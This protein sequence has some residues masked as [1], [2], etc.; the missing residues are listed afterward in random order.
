[1]A[2]KAPPLILKVKPVLPVADAVMLPFVATADVGLTVVAVKEIVIPAQ[3]LGAVKVNA[4]EPVHP[5]TSFATIVYV[6]AAR[7]A[8]LPEDWKAPPFILNV[9][10]ELPEAVAFMLPLLT[11]V[12]VGLTAVPVTVIVTPAHRLIA[13]KLNVADPVHPL[14]FFATIVYEPADKLAKLPDDWNALPLIL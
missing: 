5:F 1:V 6:P 8:K 12:D 11:K 2:W 4:A 9:K 14:E 7:F 3:G 13:V 10:P